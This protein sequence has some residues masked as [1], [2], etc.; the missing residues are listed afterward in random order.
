MRDKYYTVI[1]CR[2]TLNVILSVDA[3]VA[4]SRTFPLEI[5]ASI[6]ASAALPVNTV[7]YSVIAGVVP[8]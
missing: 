6:V 3:G 4:R 5:S 1:Q 8:S 2:T 7:P